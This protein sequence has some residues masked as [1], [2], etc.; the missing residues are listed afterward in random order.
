MAQ[1]GAGGARCATLAGAQVPRALRT[2]LSTPARLLDEGLRHLVFADR[3]LTSGGHEGP[4][5][6]V[7]GA[8]EVELAGLEPGLGEL[9]QRG[10]LSYLDNRVAHRFRGWTP[11]TPVFCEAL[12]YPEEP[13]GGFIRGLH[14]G[15]ER[16]V[17]LVFGQRVPAP[18]K[19]WGLACVDGGFGRRWRERGGGFPAQGPGGRSQPH[20]Q[21]A[22]AAVGWPPQPRRGAEAGD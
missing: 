7:D 22:L 9:H 19:A 8:G 10:V 17:L 11:P 1:G 15:P 4:I 21:P 16:L 13:R 6:L 3:P 20:K 12:K 5:L 18:N 14:G 2:L